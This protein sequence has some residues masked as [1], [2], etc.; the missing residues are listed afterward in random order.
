MS[1]TASVVVFQAFKVV[2]EISGT[3]T[4]LLGGD[5]YARKY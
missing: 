3:L 4:E 1:L 2:K 5:P